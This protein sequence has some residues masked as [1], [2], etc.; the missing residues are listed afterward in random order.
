MVVDT[1]ISP[2][3]QLL[4]LL[5]ESRGLS[6]NRKADLLKRLENILLSKLRPSEK[7]LAARCWQKQPADP[8]SH[9]PDTKPA[10]S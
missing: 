7:S 4:A 5:T 2:G 6:G 9:L 1:G 3:S 8:L 10:L